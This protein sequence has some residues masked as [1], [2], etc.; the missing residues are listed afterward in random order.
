MPPSNHLLPTINPAYYSTILP[1]LKGAKSSGLFVIRR[2]CLISL[3]DYMNPAFRSFDASHLDSGQCIVKLA[4]V[5]GPIFIHT[6][7]QSRS[8][9]RD[10]RS[11]L[12][13]RSTAAVPHKTTLRK[14]P[15]LPPRGTSLS[16]AL[17][18][19]I[20]FC[21]IEQGAPCDRR[22][23]RWRTS[24]LRSLLSFV[25]KTKLAPPV[26]STFVLVAAS[27]Y[28][29][30]VIACFACALTYGMKTHSVIAALP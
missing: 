6:A 30:S 18:S 13:G 2:I 11:F 19:E 4:W 9:C 14:I 26:S 17:Q 3:F 7:W 15:V 5:T 23:N 29:F 27:R 21:H 25:T 1:V 22:K 24:A 16:S 20:F 10:P 28:I 8:P 12:P